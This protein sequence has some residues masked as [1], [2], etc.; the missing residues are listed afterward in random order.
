[1]PAGVVF[2]L[3]VRLA[4]GIAQTPLTDPTLAPQLLESA[5]F[6]QARQRWFCHLFLLMPDHFHAL[7]AFPAA[8][9]MSRVVGDWKRYHTAKHRVAWQEGYFDHRLRSEDEFQLKA[10]YIREIP[11]QRTSAPHRLSGHG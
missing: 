2:H 3:R 11:S 7:L 4:L 8:E 9:A 5:A 6:Y 1:M 10:D